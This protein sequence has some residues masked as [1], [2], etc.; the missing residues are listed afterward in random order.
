M[1]DIKLIALDLDGTLLNNKKEISKENLEALAMAREAGVQVIF[2]TGRPLVSAKLYQQQLGLIGSKDYSIF[3]NGGLITTGSDEILFEKCLTFDE[4]MEIV[5]VAKKADLPCDI[6]SSSKSYTIEF[7]RKSQVS[8][9]NNTMEFIS[10]NTDELPREATFNKIILSADTKFLDTV[11]AQFDEQFCKKFEICKTRDI[12]LEVMPKGVNKASGLALLC[13]KLK[14]DSSEV[15]A[16]GD[17]D[18]DA[19][20]LRWAGLGVAPA[21]SNVTA[22]TSANILS[23]LTNDEHAVADAINKYVLK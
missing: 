1:A 8:F 18:N 3:L 19:A 11:L 22:R 14:I 17:E 7:G 12:L 4:V 16:M 6:I 13:K 23:T 20:M 10:I 9:V 21:N 5:S 2:D 15:L